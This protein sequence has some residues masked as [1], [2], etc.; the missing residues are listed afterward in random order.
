VEPDVLAAAVCRAGPAAIDTFVDHYFDSL[1]A[2]A[3]EDRLG[4]AWMERLGLG[5]GPS[6]TSARRVYAEAASLEHAWLARCGIE[7]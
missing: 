7:E 6:S 5:G 2:A 4:D 3:K 1:D